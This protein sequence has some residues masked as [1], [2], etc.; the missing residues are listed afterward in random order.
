MLVLKISSFS[1]DH[2]YKV[3]SGK[4]KNRIHF[5]IEPIQKKTNFHR[6]IDEKTW[7]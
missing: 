2:H 4:M 5:K 3:Y 6:L 1:V 7:E